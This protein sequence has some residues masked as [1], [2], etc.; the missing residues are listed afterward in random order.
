MMSRFRFFSGIRK[1]QTFSGSLSDAQGHKFESSPHYHHV[2]SRHR[3]S[4]INKEG[5][6]RSK[7]S[8]SD[9]LPTIHDEEQFETMDYPSMASG[10]EMES[11]GK[12]MFSVGQS[13]SETEN[14]QK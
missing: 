8:E 14:E 12:K 9:K 5:R 4:G 6:K 7:K 10:S 3:P 2:M 11:K 13:E 1:A